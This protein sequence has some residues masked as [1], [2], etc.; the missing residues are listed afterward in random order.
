MILNEYGTLKSIEMLFA[1]LLPG[2]LFVLLYINFLEITALMPFVNLQA[3]EMRNTPVLILLLLVSGAC[4]NVCLPLL[5]YLFFW[6]T[7]IA[8][9]FIDSKVIDI[10]IMGLQ[11]NALE[12]YENCLTQ[13]KIVEKI[14]GDGAKLKMILSLSAEKR[15]YFEQYEQIHNGL[16]L[17]S[18]LFHIYF[19]ICIL[20]FLVYI[21]L[22]LY[23]CYA[24]WSSAI[25]SLF[26]A[27]FFLFAAWAMFRMGVNYF[28]MF[29][30]LIEP[31][32]PQCREIPLAQS[33][34]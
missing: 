16:L 2:S 27:L 19:L 17:A 21:Y 24:Y 3:S 11:G 4:L 34:E 31:S 7:N 8:I 12:R 25:F 9:K 22:G 6:H 29:I 14:L 33:L 10:K 5:R 13:Y 15:R 1:Y 30:E 23:I 32:N 28:I 18:I 20:K 26:L